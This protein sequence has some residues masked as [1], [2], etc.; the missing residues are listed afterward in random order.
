MLLQKNASWS[1][2]KL[3]IHRIRSS[4]SR[5]L[6]ETVDAVDASLLI[7]DHTTLPGG[8]ELALT[9][10]AGLSKLNATFAFLQK[11]DGRLAFPRR[12]VVLAPDRSLGAIQQL[13]FLRTVLRRHKQSLIVSNT[14]RV[15]IYVVLLKGRHQEHVLL[16]HDGIDGQSLSPLK[17]AIINWLVLSR[18]KAIV[19]NSRWTA[20]TVPEK[21]QGLLT[22]VAHSFSGTTGNEH[23]GRV[24]RTDA[25]PLRLLSLSRLVKWKGVHLVLDALE[26]LAKENFGERDLILTIA[27][28]AILG[29][30]K[31]AAELKSRAK[32]L[33]FSVEFVGQV[34]QIAP[35]LLS[36][37]VLV[38]AS[39]RPE[40][41]GQVIVQGL[42]YGLVVVA[43]DSG[44]PAEILNEES[45]LLFTRGSSISL[46]NALRHLLES[47]EL[48]KSLVE[49]GQVAAISYSDSEIVKKFD[50]IF[51]SVLGFPEVLQEESKIS[52][53]VA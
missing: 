38:H 2:I 1:L 48:R 41:F 24:E 10:F 37:D 3:K 16:L 52:D 46:A 9:H 35:L 27:G 25:R 50:T 6:P 29:P 14:L 8:A 22:T 15:G 26:I 31:Y 36:N 42:S 13:H 18:T 11:N 34:A 19:P 4:F 44:G 5:R 51:R 39:V 17:R 7:V 28:S 23:R 47:P 45:G 12:T 40:P 43:P 32:L 21:F 53:G 33:P 30:D 49:N 20:S